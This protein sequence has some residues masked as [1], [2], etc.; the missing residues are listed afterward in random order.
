MLNKLGFSIMDIGSTPPVFWLVFGQLPLYKIWGGTSFFAFS[1]SF[2]VRDRNYDIDSYT[3][4]ITYTFLYNKSVAIFP[5]RYVVP[6]YLRPTIVIGYT[7]YNNGW[8][9][10]GYSLY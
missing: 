1:N 9:Y 5:K 6:I 4:F 8:S 7:P 10:T 3:M 2:P